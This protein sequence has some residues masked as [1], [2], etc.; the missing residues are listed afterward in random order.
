MGVFDKS[1]KLKIFTRYWNTNVKHK[2]K[3]I[4]FY[5]NF[6]ILH[7]PADKIFLSNFLKNFDHISDPKNEYFNYIQSYQVIFKNKVSKFLP[8]KL[9]NLIKY[10]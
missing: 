8:Q 2:Q 1:V 9:K 5:R 7:L 3:N 4:L 6:K 10:A